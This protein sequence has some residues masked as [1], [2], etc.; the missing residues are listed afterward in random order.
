MYSHEKWMQDRIK[1]IVDNFHGYRHGLVVALDTTLYQSEGDEQI[2]LLPAPNDV[3][4]I[5]SN[6][7]AVNKN[8][9]Q[10]QQIYVPYKQDSLHAIKLA[11]RMLSL[12]SYASHGIP[13][14]EKATY[15]GP[16]PSIPMAGDKFRHPSLNGYDLKFLLNAI[17]IDSL[18][19]DEWIMLAYFRLGS[20]ADSEYYRFLSYLQVIEVSFMNA[21]KKVDAWINSTRQ[22]DEIE[23][24]LDTIPKHRKISGRLR[25][26]RNL[27]AHVANKGNGNP[28]IVTDPDDIE[29][30]RQVQNDLGII[31]R[32]AIERIR[33]IEAFQN[34]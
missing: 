25:E 3:P 22:I 4:F 32:L 33:A 1:L 10:I 21:R 14:I 18:K 29:S 24:W 2:F 27:C 34:I 16:Y 12:L 13:I 20:N 19:E 17:E 15:G 30:V 7:V 31:R 8:E 23:Q 11:R 6:P 28:S 5:W 26:T 9:I